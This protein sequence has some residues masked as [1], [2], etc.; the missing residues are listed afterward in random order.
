MFTA[1]FCYNINPHYLLT[2]D[3]LAGTTVSR[4]LR[5][6]ESVKTVIII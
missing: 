3:S 1:S 2:R 5:I 6:Y 4:P